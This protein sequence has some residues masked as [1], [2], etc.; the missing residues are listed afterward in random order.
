MKLKDFKVLYVEDS[1]AMQAYIKKLLIN[2]TKRIFIAK[3]GLEGLELYK[4]HKPDIIIS[5]IE[6]PNLDGLKMSKTIKTIDKSVP[7]ILL[8]QLDKTE[9]LKDAIKIGIKS[10]VSK[11]FKEEEI[12]VSLEE[13]ANELHNEIELKRLKDLELQNEKVELMSTFLKEIGHHWKQPLSH[14]MSISSSYEIKKKAAFYESIDEEIEEMN[15]ITDSVSLL[16]NII[17]EVSQLDFNTFDKS[18]LDNLVRISDP[19][20]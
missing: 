12:M 9:N 17:D 7:I 13:I 11:P 20:N 14:I 6:M 1:I 4:K 19:V 10:F 2:E 15:S 3:D 16:S 18:A 5:D 8:T